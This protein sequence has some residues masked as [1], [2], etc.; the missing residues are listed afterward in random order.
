MYKIIY[1][2]LLP[3]NE[4]LENLASQFKGINFYYLPRTKN[5]FVDALTTLASIV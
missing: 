5:Q 1:E 2:K 3:N 4:H